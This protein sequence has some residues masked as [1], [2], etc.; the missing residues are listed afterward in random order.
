MHI[1]ANKK[2]AN[3]RSAKNNFRICNITVYTSELIVSNVGVEVG[4]RLGWKKI[5]VELDVGEVNG[6][7]LGSTEG[8]KV[9]ALVG[10]AVG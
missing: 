7:R 4:S 10:E 1:I 2:S 3:A 6:A 8:C 5:T 9:G